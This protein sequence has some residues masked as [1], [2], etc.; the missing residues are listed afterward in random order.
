MQRENFKRIYLEIRLVCV[1]M[2]VQDGHSVAQYIYSTRV[3]VV[4]TTKKV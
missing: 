1:Y 3:C 4:Y 2:C